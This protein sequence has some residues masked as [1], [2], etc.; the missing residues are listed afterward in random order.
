MCYRYYILLTCIVFL[1]INRQVNQFSVV[2][3]AVVVVVVVVNFVSSV[4]CK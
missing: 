4:K 2:M 1:M 3:L